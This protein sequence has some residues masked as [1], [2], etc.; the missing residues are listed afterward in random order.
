MLEVALDK[1][2]AY[3][4][5]VD[6]RYVDLE[7]QMKTASE[8]LGVLTMNNAHLKSQLAEYETEILKLKQ[9]LRASQIQ[10][11]DL[12]STLKSLRSS[13]SVPVPTDNSKMEVQ[14]VSGSISL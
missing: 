3:I 10:V 1:S 7:E 14:M 4:T 6:K 5:T 8:A 13:M 12:T 9:K 11:I 2:Q